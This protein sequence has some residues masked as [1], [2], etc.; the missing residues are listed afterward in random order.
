MPGPYYDEIKDQKTREERYESA[1]ID[2]YGEEEQL[3]AICRYAKR[4]PKIP[5]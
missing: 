4:L 1:T 5:V 3:T 2:C